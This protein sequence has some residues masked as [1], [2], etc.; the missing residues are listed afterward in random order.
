MR[1]EIEILEHIDQLVTKG[2]WL[3]CLIALLVFLIAFRK[4]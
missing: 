1:T 3:L 4:Y 2:N